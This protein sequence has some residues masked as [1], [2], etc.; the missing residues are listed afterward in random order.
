MCAS[1]GP[2]AN[3]NKGVAGRR[4][5]GA[6]CDLVQT[7]TVAAEAI[8][9]WVRRRREKTQH[10]SGCFCTWPESKHRERVRGGWAFLDE[11]KWRE[12]C[13]N[14]LYRFKVH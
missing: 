2:P 6:Q 14:V 9:P 8:Y 10:E 3:A 13:E 11:R 12:R 1:I 5:M 4:L 7:K